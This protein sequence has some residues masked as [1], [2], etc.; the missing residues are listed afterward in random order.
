MKKIILL[1]FT[2]LF[3]GG[4]CV[5]I[6]PIEQ[7]VITVTEEASEEMLDEATTTEPTEEEVEH[8]IYVQFVVNVHDW[9]FPEESAETL[10]RLIDLHEEYQIPVEFHL[11]GATTQN[12]V[13][14]S[15]ELMERLRTS[16]YV[17]V[18]YH[19]RPPHPMYSNFDTVGLRD[20]SANDR[21]ETLF[22]FESHRLDMETGRYV[23]EPGGYQF[24]KDQLGYAP[25]I[26]GATNGRGGL[27][28]SRV[29]EEMGALFTV[30]HEGGS[31]LE[32]KVH[33]LN[34]RP[35]DQ[36]VKLYEFRV[37]DRFDPEEEFAEWTE[38]F[39]GSKDWF[40]N[41]KY[42]E[43]NFYLGGTPFAPIYWEDWDGDRKEAFEPPY[44]L[45]AS[46][47]L[48]DFRSEAQQKGHWD[49]YTEALDY[50]DEN[51]DWL[52]P[53]NSVDLEGMLENIQ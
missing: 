45:N 36:E 41:L 35:E 38:G 21:Y 5:S 49:L 17:A 37:P 3:L 50:V 18:S 12:Y 7:E 33:G 31:N 6:E 4:G 10:D 47:D 27:E 9:V 14:I 48:V 42:H 16:E 22:A 52:T 26:V 23:D 13:D 28:Y 2:L 15:P 43:N 40:V 39:D 51:L 32:D 25:R 20:M 24:L 11:T 53:I 34:K 46:Y 8:S 1:S 19:V 29:L 30:L 44:D